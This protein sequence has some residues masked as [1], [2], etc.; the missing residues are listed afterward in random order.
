MVAM[1]AQVLHSENATELLRQVIS[2]P[3]HAHCRDAVIM[4]SLSVHTDASLPAHTALLPPLQLS[5]SD[6]DDMDQKPPKS[7]WKR[8]RWRLFFIAASILLFCGSLVLRVLVPQQ[9]RLRSSPQD[10]QQRATC[11]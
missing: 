11:L 5:D 6:F 1:R 9:V 4:T 7:W 8:W 10:T 2:H 3:Q